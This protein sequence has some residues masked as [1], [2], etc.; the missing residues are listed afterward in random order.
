MKRDT[1]AIVGAGIV[2]SATAYA[3][4]LRNIPAD[5]ILVDSNDIRCKGEVEDLADVLPLSSAHSITVGSLQM[6]A[7]AD[8]LIITAGIAQGCGQSRLDLLHTNACTMQDIFKVLK[9]LLNPNIII[10]VVT[11]PVD[12]LTRLVQELSELPTRQIFGAGTFLDTERL[13]MLISNE[14]VIA[15]ESIDLC[16]I[17]EHGDSQVV[18]WSCAMIAEV[19]LLQFPGLTKNQLDAM[20][21][22]TKEKAYD[23]I[24]CKGSTSFGVAACIALYCQTIITDTKQII[25]VSCFNPLYGIYMSMP[26]VLG[27]AGVEQVISLSL[28]ND[29]RVALESSVQLLK[30]QYLSLMK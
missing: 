2:G 15:P 23:V 1:I 28:S 29:E 5:I 20:A 26:A 25:P 27:A 8:I 11:N 19:P 21:Q 30:E 18:A 9:P 13:R 6:A 3:L 17:G 14:L 7:N 4:M 16:V 12:I 22:K 24:A 10:I